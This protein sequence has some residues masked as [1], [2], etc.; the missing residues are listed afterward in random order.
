MSCQQPCPWCCWSSRRSAALVSDAP[1]RTLFHDPEALR[2]TA[3]TS[4]PASVRLSFFSCYKSSS[5]T[6]HCPPPKQ[7]NGS[8]QNGLHIPFKSALLKVILS[9]MTFWDNSWTLLAPDTF[10]ASSRVACLSAS[11]HLQRPVLDGTVRQSV[12]VL[13]GHIADL[14]TAGERSDP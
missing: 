11:S 5:A 13:P 8:S 6:L 1:L 14:H 12:A 7:G 3:R 4:A 10:C 2:K 9:M